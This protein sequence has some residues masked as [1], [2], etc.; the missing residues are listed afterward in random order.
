MG[1]LLFAGAAEE[2]LDQCG[3]VLDGAA[4][5]IVLEHPHV[6]ADIEDAGAVAVGLGD[7]DA[8][9]FVEVERHGIREHRLGGPEFDF[10]AGGD[11]HALD[12]LRGFVGG[13]RDVGRG[14][15][16]AGV[17]DL[18][19]DDGFFVVVGGRGCGGAERRKLE[20]GGGKQRGAERAETFHGGRQSIGGGRDEARRADWE[21]YAG[22]S[23]GGGCL[24]VGRVCDPPSVR[25]LN[26]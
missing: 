10:E 21:K 2:P 5:E 20:N 4:R 9:L 7:E 3:A 13:G 23:G 24:V 8:A 17:E 19:A 25:S 16:R 15:T 26:A 22:V 14:V 11:L 6:V 18:A 1:K 12:G